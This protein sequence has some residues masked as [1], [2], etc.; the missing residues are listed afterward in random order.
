M[1]GVSFE[2]VVQQYYEPL[3]KFAFS[4]TR[5]EADAG[6]LTQQTDQWHSGASYTTVVSQTNNGNTSQVTMRDN[7]PIS[8]DSPRFIRV[9]V[10]EN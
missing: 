2:S 6:D 5:T 8:P 10:T 7:T 9:Q 1:T 3:Y 4:L